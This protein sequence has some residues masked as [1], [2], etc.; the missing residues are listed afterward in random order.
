MRRTGLNGARPHKSTRCGTS[1]WTEYKLGQGDDS[2]P[3]AIVLMRRSPPLRLFAYLGNW[4]YRLVA[5]DLN[6]RS[7]AIS[8]ASSSFADSVLLPI[9]SSA[10]ISNA[11][12]EHELYVRDV[13]HAG[14]Q[15]HQENPPPRIARYDADMAAT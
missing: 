12:C 5:S 2:L 13:L 15:V 4:T 6:G 10:T 8:L 1:P 9:S 3:T 11:M 14:R 7:E